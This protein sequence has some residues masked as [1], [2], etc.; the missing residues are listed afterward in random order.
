MRELYDL[1]GEHGSGRQALVE[2]Y[3]VGGKTGTAEKVVNGRYVGNKRFNA[4]LASFP[5][6]IRNMSCW[7][8][9]T[10]RSQCPDRGRARR[11]P[12]TPRRPPAR[13]FDARRRCLAS[14]RNFGKGDDALLVS[15]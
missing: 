13:S 15:Y 3:E 12:P 5:I 9:S 11:L 14:P 2:G 7:S 6:R 8:S 1:N 10:S 4:Y